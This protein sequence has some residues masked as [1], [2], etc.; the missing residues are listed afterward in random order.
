MLSTI[1]CVYVLCT[2][3][4]IYVFLEKE[5]CGLSPNTYVYVSVTDLYIHRIGPRMYLAAAK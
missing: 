1:V 3:K 4:P 5:L 2:E